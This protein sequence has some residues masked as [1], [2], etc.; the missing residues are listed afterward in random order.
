MNKKNK[1]LL[2]CEDNNRLF[3]TSLRSLHIAWFIFLSLQAYE[4]DSARLSPC[5]YWIPVRDGRFGSKVYTLEP[6]L[7]ALIPVNTT[8]PCHLSGP[9]QRFRSKVGQIGT[10]LDKPLSH[11]LIF[12]KV[13]K[14]DL[15]NSRFVPFGAILTYIRFKAETPVVGCCSNIPSV[16]QE[17]KGLFDLHTDQ[18]SQ[19]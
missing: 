12:Q 1:V 19:I 3:L 14:S 4:N 2:I 17:G 18:E 10:K 15:K 13:R 11:T 16:N 7:P 5:H 8:R 9:C 6:K